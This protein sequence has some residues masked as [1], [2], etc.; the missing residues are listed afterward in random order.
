MGGAIRATL[1]TMEKTT[2][3]LPAA[4]K[5]RLEAVA[6]GEGRTQADL[7]REAIERYLVG[8]D[9]PRPRWG[10]AEECPDDGITSENLDRFLA[11]AWGDGGP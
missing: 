2:L 11:R 5:D 8:K 7:A 6:R 4:L 10:I 1:T 3:Y 9:P